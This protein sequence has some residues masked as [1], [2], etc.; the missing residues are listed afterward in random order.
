MKRPI[1]IT[2]TGIICAVTTLTATAKELNPKF[3]LLP[4]PQQ[5]EV[6]A[7]NALAWNDVTYIIADGEAAIPVLGD[8]L[9]RLP[10]KAVAGKGVTLS[11]TTDAVPVKE[12]GYVVEVSQ[13]GI[14]VKARS[15]AG[16]FYGCQTVE[17]LIEDSY[18]QNICI[19]SMKITDYPSID[20]RAIH[21]DTKH[22]L[23][24]TEYYYRTIDRLARYKINAVIW[25]IEDKLL[26]QSHPE[27]AAANAISKQEMLA[28]SRYA[29]ERNIEI[30]PL[31]QGLGHASFILKHHW[32]LRES[33]ASDW[34]FCPSN[35]KTYE[36]QF[37]LYRDAL[38]AMPYGRFLHVGGD[39]ISA[40]GIDERCKATGKTPFELQMDWLGKVCDFAIANGRTPIFWDDM[41]L[42]NADLWWLLHGGLSDDEVN[43]LWNTEKLDASKSLFPT[44]CVYM[45]WHYEDPTTMP[46]RRVLEWYK[47]A[48][49]QVMAATSASTGDCPF[50][51]RDD[52]RAENIKN[53]SQL[54]VENNLVGILATVWDDGSPHWETV[55]RGMI[56]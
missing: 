2:L 26:Y 27:I 41:P 28:I 18:E 53:F 8:M 9:D 13:K 55:A 20:Y 31:V 10:R 37:D 40:I 1:I 54:T 6:V 3:Q 39:E 17:Q 16:L 49:L 19:P 11:L 15:A 30:S 14:T 7:D 51:P 33:P 45:R 46:H 50:L 52:S 32:E 4:L 25:E 47:T 22:H 23:D 5:I 44:D 43:K 38:E 34:E 48:G 24:R 36:F 42:K 35:P 56:A 12:E 29:K 21:F